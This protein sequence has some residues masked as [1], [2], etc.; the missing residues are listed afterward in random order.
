MLIFNI[1]NINTGFE[2]FRAKF[3]SPL[4]N[5]LFSSIPTQ[6]QWLLWVLYNNDGMLVDTI[7]RNIIA[8]TLN[9]FGYKTLVKV[10]KCERKIITR[11]S[12]LKEKKHQNYKVWLV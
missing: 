2:L 1:L 12:F 3:K 8:N 11:G 10:V 7:N 4:G 6:L 9:C 5:S